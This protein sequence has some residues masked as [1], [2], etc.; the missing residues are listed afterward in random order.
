MG[1]RKPHW[2]GVRLTG[3]A[4]SGGDATPTLPGVASPPVAF[5]VVQQYVTEP[6]NTSTKKK[7]NDRRTRTASDG[8]DATPVELESVTACRGP[9]QRAVLLA[10]GASAR[11]PA[12]DDVVSI[13]NAMWSRPGKSIVRREQVRIRSFRLVPVALRQSPRRSADTRSRHS[14]WRTRPRRREFRTPGRHDFPST[15]RD[16]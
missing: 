7:K 11:P 13:F 16:W 15:C 1:V 8:G 14:E 5:T 10:N 4:H 6:R 2:R 3:W 12:R 9:T